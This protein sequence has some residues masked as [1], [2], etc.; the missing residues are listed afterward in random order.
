MTKTLLASA[1]ALAM[2]SGVA[3]AQTDS[4]VSTQSTTVTPGGYNSSTTQRSID[5]NGNALDKSQSYHSGVGGTDSTSNSHSTSMDGSVQS[6]THEKQVATPDGSS[7]TYKK[8][9]TTTIGQ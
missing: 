1:A 2:L 4:S 9:T 6:S 3:F 7:A 5:A 8:S